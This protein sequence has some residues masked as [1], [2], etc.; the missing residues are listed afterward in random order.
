MSI[1][2]R[3]SD[4]E[5]NYDFSLMKKVPV[6]IRVS[7]RSFNSVTRDLEKPYCPVMSGLMG[8]TMVKTISQIDGAVFGYHHSDEIN[9]I[10]RNDQSLNT[11]PWF[12]NKIQKLCSMSASMVTYNFLDLFYSLDNQ[13]DLIGNIYFDSV[14]FA[15]PDESE[16]AN[17]LVSRQNQSISNALRKSMS[18]LLRAKD[19]Q[20]QTQLLSSVLKKSTQDQIDFHNSKFGVDFY[21]AYPLYFRNG[22]S[23]YKVPKFDE[24]SEKRNKWGLDFETPSFVE[25]RSWVISKLQVDRNI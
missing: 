21:K 22:L 9:F 15:V 4:Y 19:K 5:S 25:K 8:S 23:S 12:G 17:Y 14:V 20:Y 10:L 6:I 2:K 11:D 16:A 7:G 18:Y 1:S 24:D 13:P 3:F